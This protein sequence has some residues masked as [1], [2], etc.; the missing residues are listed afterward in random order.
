ML[1]EYPHI[2]RSDIVRSEHFQVD[3]ISRPGRSPVGHFPVGTFPG[4]D[5]SRSEHFLFPVGTLAGN[6]KASCKKLALLLNG[7]LNDREI[8]ILSIIAKGDC[9]G[10][11]W[12]H[13]RIHGAH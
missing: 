12:V 11:G 8:F 6:R 7:N 3:Y 4:R 10:W 2:S 1:G 5:T 13:G 9:N